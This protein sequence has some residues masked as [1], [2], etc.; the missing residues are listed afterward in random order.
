MLVSVIVPT[1]NRAAAL[2]GALAS[3]ARQEAGS[4]PY[5]VI[6]VDNGSTDATRRVAEDA[7]TALPGLHYAY[8][9]RPG[10]HR[11]RHRGMRE[12]K[13]DL[14]A[15]IDDDVEVSPGWIASLREALRDDSVA[16]VGGNILPAFVDTPPP[17]LLRLWRRP[18]GDGHAIPSLSVLAWRGEARDID[19]AL[20]WGCNLSVRRSVLEAA[21]GFHP[22]A[23]PDDLIKFRGDG[24]MQLGRFVVASGAR[25]LFH[26]GAS[27]RHLVPLQRMTFDY[28]RRRAFL[29][30]QQAGVE[31]SLKELG[32]ECQRLA[33]GGDR[34]LRP[35]E[36]GIA[37]GKIEAR[38]E[39]L[40]V[41]RQILFQQCHRALVLLG[42]ERL[43]GSGQ[44]IWLA[45]CLLL[46]RRR[47]G[48]GRPE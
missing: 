14:L 39:M 22:D 23:M 43:L 18:Y 47:A 8:E 13:G 24:E 11:G 17:W 21:R 45:D 28:F 4:G 26:P 48:N 32:V 12:A 40:G 37:I 35:A 36:Q 46:V 30:Q 2:A 34:L 44:G 16:M 29:D 41:L 9:A 1:R 7:R 19:P 33:I 3:L 42:L 6:V 5:E 31:I 38:P 20:V 15:F 10:L 25:C 27:V